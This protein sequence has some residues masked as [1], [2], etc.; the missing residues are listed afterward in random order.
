MAAGEGQG[1]VGVTLHVV[2]I[3]MAEPGCHH[4]DQQLILA[5]FFD[6]DVDDLPLTW[7]VEQHR[8]SCSHG[9]LLVATDLA[10]AM[11][12]V[13]LRS[14]E[15]ERRTAHRA[16]SVWIDAEQRENGDDSADHTTWV[17][18]GDLGLV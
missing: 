10:Q 7:C 4:L 3:G 12:T 17:R 6:I 5:W 8:S 2:V 9:G 18:C 15:G 13:G 1:H 11:A 16:I 14:N